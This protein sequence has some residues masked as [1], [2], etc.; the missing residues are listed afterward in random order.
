M[1][2]H[3][4]SPS[5]HLHCSKLRPSLVFQPAHGSGDF[6][7]DSEHSAVHKCRDITPREQQV[8]WAPGSRCMRHSESTQGPLSV[9]RLWNGKGQTVEKQTKSMCLHSV[10]LSERTLNGDFQVNERGKKQRKK[11]MPAKAWRSLSPPCTYHRKYSSVLI[12]NY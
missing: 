3:R 2:F 7:D 5:F 6:V 9:Q 1:L 10:N 8:P 4:L 12:S 11:H